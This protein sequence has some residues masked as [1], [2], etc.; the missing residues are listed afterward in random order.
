MGTHPEPFFTFSSDDGVIS[1]RIEGIF[2]E[3]SG[4]RDGADIR[5]T[6]KIPLDGGFKTILT[7]EPAEASLG[8]TSSSASRRVRQNVTN[9]S[10]HAVRK[11]LERLALK[12]VTNQPDDDGYV[13]IAA[14]KISFIRSSGDE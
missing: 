8:N 2:G 1:G 6:L 11:V 3:F 13:E 14:H 10:D 7:V 5:A 4:F 9:A 12:G